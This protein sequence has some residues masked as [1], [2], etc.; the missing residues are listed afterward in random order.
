MDYMAAET[1][2]VLHDGEKV[3]VDHKDVLALLGNPE[4]VCEVVQEPMGELSTRVGLHH[5]YLLL[6]SITQS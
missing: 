1:V 4:E 3:G 6:L 2:L 5:S